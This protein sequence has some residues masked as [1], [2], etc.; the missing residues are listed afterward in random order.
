MEPYRAALRPDPRRE[1]SYLNPVDPHDWFSLERLPGRGY[2]KWASTLAGISLTV[3]L[4]FTFVG[5]SAALFKVGE[6]GS[7][8]AE[9]REAIA[10]I[11]RIS[12]A[13]F[14][15]SMAGIVAYICL[16][17]AARFFASKQAKFV[18]GF[19]SA[20]QKLSAPVTPESLLLDQLEEAK[21]QSGRLKTLKDDLAIVFDSS[22]NK[23]VGPLLDALPAAVGGIVEAIH[24][25]GNSIGHGNQAALEGLINQLISAVKDATGREM[26]MLV[27][28]MQA[29]AKELS[30]AKS[31]IGDGG[32]E[33]GRALTAAA[34]KAS[35][36]LS[37]ASERASEVLVRSFQES[38]ARILDA[39][40]GAVAG[41]RAATESLAGR[42]GVVEQGLGDVEQ[43]VRR[44][45]DHLS[46][47]GGVLTDAGRSFGA[48]SDQL[49]QATG[50]VLSTLQT[51]ERLATSARDTLQIIQEASSALRQAGAS[52]ASGSEAAK[53]T[54]ESHKQRF[55]SA[56][57]SLGRT[58]ATMRDGFV[59]VSD[60]VSTVVRQY[61]EHLARAVGGLR[62]AAEELAEA[63]SE[64]DSKLAAD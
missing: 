8:T 44:N 47:A 1:G 3:G 26:G 23:N 18:R 16:T 53:A 48:A 40:E 15:T 22:L 49:R 51:V 57:E 20:V 32:A 55:E 27:E 13:K 38:T 41:Y 43:A 35:E 58:F 56:D 7:N 52:M 39:V 46:E 63:V 36:T 50:P 60:Q 14:I 21:E 30:A 29:A 5:L 45:V 54:F 37:N 42:L 9:L 24:G 10:E 28:A 12:S 11:L 33:F 61:D 2:E 64:R 25:V 19:A 4:L 6:A 62:A 34:A 17:F 31:G 59:A